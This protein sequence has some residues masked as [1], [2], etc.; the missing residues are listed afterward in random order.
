MSDDNNYILIDVRVEVFIICGL[1]FVVF[2][3]FPI[4]LIC[5]NHVLRKLCRYLGCDCVGFGSTDAGDEISSRRLRRT[6]YNLLSSAH[7]TKIERSRNELLRKCLEP[8]SVCL[9]EV[10]DVLIMKGSQDGEFQCESAS[11]KKLQVRA[12][13]TE[14]T[15]FELDCVSVHPFDDDKNSFTH[16][17]IPHPGYDRNFIHVGTRASIERRKKNN[18]TDKKGFR[19]M[20]NALRGIRRQDT[21]QQ[22]ASNDASEPKDKRIVAKF[23]AICLASYEYH[24]NISWSSNEACTHVFHTKCIL[25]W[26]SSLG[27][28]W[29]RNQP[30][31]DNPA[32]DELLG[33]SLECPCCRQDFVSKLMLV[34][35]DE[36]DA[37][38]EGGPAQNL[39]RAS[40]ESA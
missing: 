8:Y 26:L 15:E 33:Y 4:C 13:Q 7:K 22:R 30:F 14:S 34:C 16:V 6:H 3:I 32:W 35:C 2:F 39:S 11:D 40:E 9:A 24:E 28:K 25:T 12:T 20:L 5:V 38:E 31:S 23:C 36:D 19:F 29:S 10:H 18:A 37:D 27:K 21:K 1:L 17:L